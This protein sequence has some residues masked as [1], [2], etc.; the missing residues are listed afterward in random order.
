MKQKIRIG[1][2]C[3]ASI[4]EKRF[5]PAL[6]KNQ[7]FAYIGVAHA[8]VEERF[9]SNQERSIEVLRRGQEKASRFCQTF[10]GRIFDSYQDMLESDQIDAVYIPLPP[11]LHYDWAMK[12]LKQGKHVLVEKP[13]TTS[14]EDTAKLVEMANN[15]NLALCENY[16]F[17]FHH[18]LQKIQEMIKQEEVGS[19]RLIRIAFGFPFRGACDFRYS[20]EM[21]GGALLDCGGYTLKLASIL[22]GDTVQLVDGVLI[23][24]DEFA[25]DIYGNAVLRNESGVTAQVAF[26]MDN[27]YRCDLEIWGSQGMLVADRIF[28]A[29]PDY[30]P[31]VKYIRGSKHE[32]IT[33]E[34][35]DQFYHSLCNFEQ[36][37]QNERKRNDCK[38]ELIKQSKMV[39]QLQSKLCQKG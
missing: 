29:P 8:N 28:T 34:P 6:L 19:L 27:Q 21:G 11:A 37:I 3:P 30:V 22:L 20:K 15:R 32:I 10:G 7:N 33:F 13:S 39:A 25:V 38:A 35:D 26:G 2:L 1:V 12:A 9:A 31:S 5:M 18:Q 4:A 23:Q 17:Q 14:I 24:S 16:M 36:C